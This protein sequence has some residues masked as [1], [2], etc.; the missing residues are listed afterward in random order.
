MIVEHNI[1]SLFEIADRVY[2]LDKGSII[3]E[4][5]PKKIIESNILEKVFTAKGV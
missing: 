4:D 3:A 1:K 2:V 5:V